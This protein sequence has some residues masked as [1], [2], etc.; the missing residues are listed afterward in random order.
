MNDCFSCTH[1]KP[2]VGPDGRIDFTQ[3]RC[4]EGPPIPIVVGMDANKQLLVQAFF[5][6][7]VRNMRCDRIDIRLIG[8]ATTIEQAK[9]Q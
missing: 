1:A 8:E 6:M 3:R 4:E 5:P 9:P 7:V 2:L